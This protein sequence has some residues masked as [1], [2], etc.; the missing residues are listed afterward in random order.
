MNDE[1]RMTN[2]ELP[3]RLTRDLETLILSCRATVAA[4][5]NSALGMLYW[6]VGKRLAEELLGDDGRAAYGKRVVEETG[7]VL[8]A[9]HG[10]GFEAKNLRRMMTFAQRFPDQQIVASL[11]RQ[12]SWTHF[13]Q[14]I[15]LKDANARAWYARTAGE[16]R[17]SVRHSRWPHPLRGIVP[18]T[19]R[20]ARTPSRRH[21][22]RRILD[23]SPAQDRTRKTPA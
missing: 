6:M 5:V 20:T 21:H 14:I 12:L 13:L 2:D 9:R 22:G 10:R 23:R 16:Q 3:S 8:A 1:I 17:W 7:A 19:S 4:Q 11:M 18:R 15:P